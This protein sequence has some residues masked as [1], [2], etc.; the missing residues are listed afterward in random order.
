MSTKA[1]DPGINWATS[2]AT[3]YAESVNLLGGQIITIKKN[4]ETLTD[5]SKEVGLEVNTEKTKNMLLLSRH[6]NAGQ[7]HNTKTAN[8]SLKIWQFINLGTT[9]TNRNLINK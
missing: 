8:R 4:T 7:N 2:A 3:L 5:A 1:G 6:Q 9:V